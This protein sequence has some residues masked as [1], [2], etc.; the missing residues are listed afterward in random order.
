MLCRCKTAVGSNKNVVSK[1]DLCS[2]LHNKVVIGVKVVA[3]SDVV[4]VVAP[5]GRSHRHVFAHLANEV[6]EDA[7]LCISVIGTKLV[8]AMTLFL[9]HLYFSFICRIVA[10]LK[11]TICWN[12]RFFHGSL[13]YYSKAISSATSPSAIP[14]ILF[15]SLT[16]AIIFSSSVSL[17]WNFFL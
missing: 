14:S 15:F 1:C 3:Q 12:N 5:K 7:H 4:A 16:S 17:R 11:E 6:F 10:S 9:G 2:I 8:E 13:L